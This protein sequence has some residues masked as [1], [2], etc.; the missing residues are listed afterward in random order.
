MFYLL[1]L[2]IGL[3]ISVM[4]SLNGSL[5]AVYGT[6][7]AAMIIH[8]VGVIGALLLCLIRKEKITFK[9]AAPLWAYFGGAIGV[10]STLFNNYSFGHITM[11]SL[12]ALGLLGQSLTSLLL[13]SFGWLGMEKHP[14]KAVSLIGFLPAAAG[15][16]LMLDS[17]VTT[18][19]AALAVLLSLGAGVTIV[20]SRTV[21]ARLS[22]ETSPLIGSFI[23]H[24]VGLPICIVLA[25]LFQKPFWTASVAK[26]WMYLGG[27]LGVTVVLLLNVAVPKMP[28][29]HLT[30]LTFTG[31]IF[32]GIILDLILGRDFSSV[33][34]WGGLIIAAGLLLNMGAEQ[35]SLRNR[36]KK[37]QE[38][39]PL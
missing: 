24:L 1:A 20:L 16:I 22:K 31:E 2:L 11:T 38:K 36:T 34:F 4:V 28:A 37:N 7:T 32:T 5:T 21:N 17:S 25:L 6:Y 3:L 23:N 10:L 33:S 14:L 26:P 30:L 9:S 8:I 29:F 15:I 39:Q 13:D 18:S 27:L 12:V 35:L 19:G